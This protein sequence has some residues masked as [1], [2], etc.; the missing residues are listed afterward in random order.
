VEEVTSIDRYYYFRDDGVKNIHIYL[1]GMPTGR[2]TI[3]QFRLDRENGSS[4]DIWQR[5]GAPASLTDNQC[6]YL[7]R[8]S[9]PHYRELQC[10]VY[11]EE[12]TLLTEILD[13]HAV[14]LIILKKIGDIT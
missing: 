9:V 4:Y 7:Q 8:V 2:Y 14:V 12:E 11:E 3:E 13:S 5:M 6:E 1:K 10:D